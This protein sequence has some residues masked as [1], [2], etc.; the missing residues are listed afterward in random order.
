MRDKK[1]G[2]YTDPQYYTVPRRLNIIIYILTLGPNTQTMNPMQSK[3]VKKDSA[4]SDPFWV[5]VRD[6]QEALRWGMKKRLPAKIE[7]QLGILQAD[8][9]VQNLVPTMKIKSKWRSWVY[10]FILC[11][12]Y[13]NGETVVVNGLGKT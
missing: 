6:A 7:R 2:Y 12:S 10:G 3:K 8:C 4:Y 1:E 5:C 13:R 11:R 9:R